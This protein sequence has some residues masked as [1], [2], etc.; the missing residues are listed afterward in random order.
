MERTGEDLGAGCEQRREGQH[1]GVQAGPKSGSGGTQ[2]LIE[3]LG[4]EAKTVK[5]VLAAREIEKEKKR[6]IDYTRK[7]HNQTV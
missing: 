5:T 6:T 2:E 3:Y 4:K 1:V 7:K